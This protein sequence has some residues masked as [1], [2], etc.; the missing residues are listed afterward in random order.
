MA[1]E[2]K[3]VPEIRPVFTRQIS[4]VVP[5]SLTIFGDC[6]ERHDKRTGPINPTEPYRRKNRPRPPRSAGIPTG[7]SRTGPF[8]SLEDVETRNA[9]EWVLADI[10][11]LQEL[12]HYDVIYYLANRPASPGELPLITS[13]Y[14]TS[15]EVLNYITSQIHAIGNFVSF[16]V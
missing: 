10:R 3:E 13:D 12:Y 2:R 15:P 16:D 6:V 8:I 9:I 14:E 4:G 7:S 11:L 1:T 5:R